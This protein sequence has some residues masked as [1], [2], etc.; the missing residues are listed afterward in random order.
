MFKK[1]NIILILVSLFFITL[2]NIAYAFEPLA[3]NEQPLGL[4]SMS[5]TGFERLPYFKNGV[6]TYQFS[7]NGKEN[8]YDYGSYLY[9]DGSITSNKYTIFVF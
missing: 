5:A 3:V 4:Q 6:S 9:N 2:F 7:S 1:N 8:V